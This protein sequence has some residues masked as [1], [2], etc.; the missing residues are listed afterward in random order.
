MSI[1]R[2]DHYRVEFA[3]PN[4]DNYELVDFSKCYYIAGQM[5][6]GR[7]QSRSIC[8]NAVIWRPEC[9]AKRDNGRRLVKISPYNELVL[10]RSI[11]PNF[12][13]VYAHVDTLNAFRNFFPNN[14]QIH[15]GFTLMGFQNN[16]DAFTQIDSLWDFVMAR[17]SSV[18]IHYLPPPPFRVDDEEDL[19]PSRNR[20]LQAI[21]VIT[22]EEDQ[23]SICLDIVK[24]GMK[25]IC[26]HIF[27]SKCLKTWTDST[28]VCPICRTPI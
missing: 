16:L 14:I 25:T 22:K 9:V 20:Q 7:W 12:L 24:E 4:S 2:T 5:R 23:C 11:E 10:R 21:P 17:C 19:P 1:N 15:L 18:Y 26:L 13:I 28:P 27:C 8:L 3:T 6:G